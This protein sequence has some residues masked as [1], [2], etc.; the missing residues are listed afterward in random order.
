MRACVRASFA[1][2]HLCVVSQGVYARAPNFMC[3]STRAFAADKCVASAC[4]VT[5]RR[6]RCRRSRSSS[7]S[8]TRRRRIRWTRRRTHAKRRV[9]YA[10]RNGGGVMWARAGLS[11][12]AGRTHPLFSG[13]GPAAIPSRP[14]S[15]PPGTTRASPTHEQPPHSP[16]PPP[17]Y[18]RP[19]HTRTEIHPSRAH[20]KPHTDTDTQAHRHTETERHRPGRNMRTHGA[21]S[22]TGPG[23]EG[24]R[25][26][27]G[28]RARG[29]GWWWRRRWWGQ[30]HSVQPQ[31]RP[32]KATAGEGDSRWG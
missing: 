27:G 18:P 12:R 11:P 7:S 10:R 14:S 8:S 15:V 23:P 13:P 1:W 4:L 28:R 5:L 21:A 6:C 32:G 31:R 26:C 30:N 25:K 20:Q 24:E 9:G 17:P 29:G 3:A 22:V 19:H 16:P 2:G